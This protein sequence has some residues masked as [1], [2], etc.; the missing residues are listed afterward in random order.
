M[1]QTPVS[2]KIVY[3]EERPM[4]QHQIMLHVDLQ[5][6]HQ[7]FGDAALLAANIHAKVRVGDLGLDDD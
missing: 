6:H 3:P 1:V 4:L 2:T 7:I 5:N